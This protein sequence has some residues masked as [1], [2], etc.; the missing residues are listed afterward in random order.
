MKKPKIKTLKNG[1]P[2]IVLPHSGASVTVEVLVNTGSQFESYDQNGI[3]HFLEHMMF[4]GTH[5]QSGRD[6]MHFLDGLGARTNAFTDDEVTGFYVKSARRYWK[7]TLS[8]VADIFQNPSFPDAEIQKEKGV[9][10]G[11]INMYNDDPSSLAHDAFNTIIYG[12]QPAGRTILGPKENIKKFTQNDFIK[13]HKKYYTIENSVVIIAGDLDTKEVIFLL[14][15]Q[16]NNLS[17]GKKNKKTKTKILKKPAIELIHKPTEQSHIIIGYPTVSHRHKDYLALSL[18]SVLLGGGMSSRL[19]E[20]VREELGAGYY[21]YAQHVVY[22]D[23]GSLRIVAGIDSNRVVEVCSHIKEI[24]NDVS[25]NGITEEELKKVKQY[26]IGNFIMTMESS[27]AQAHYYG[28]RLLQGRE[29]ENPKTIIKN[30]KSITTADIH[31]VAKKYLRNDCV[32]IALVGP[33]TNKEN[34]KKNMI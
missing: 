20:K 13:Y 30:I 2:V 17:S 7:K 31:R 19:F 22:T 1:L 18:L 9:I 21:V 26:M 23:S 10:I 34:L 16:F 29:L 14:E 5:N 11:E 32:H 27:S 3:S 4:K 25:N 8:T 24:I 12:D 33:H 6:I 15:Q 28:Y